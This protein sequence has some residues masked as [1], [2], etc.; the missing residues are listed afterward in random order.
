MGF[1]LPSLVRRLC[2]EIA[3][4]GYGP[5][6]G[7]NPLGDPATIP[8]EI[9]QMDMESDLINGAVC[10]SQTSPSSARLRDSGDEN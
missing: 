6:W 3:D 4:D 10:M 5:N 8:D 1:R 7:I 9:E 2:T